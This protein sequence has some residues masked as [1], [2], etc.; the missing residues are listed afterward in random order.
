MKVETM[1]QQNPSAAPRVWSRCI[2]WNRDPWLRALKML[3]WAIHEHE[4][5]VGETRLWE[6]VEELCEQVI[7]RATGGRRASRSR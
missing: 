1:P 2:D 5:Y 6:R 4:W 7:E 3:A